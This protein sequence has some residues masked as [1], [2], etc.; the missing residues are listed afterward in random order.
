M[1]ETAQKL[2]D[3]ELVFREEKLHNSL[4]VLLVCVSETTEGEVK[5]TVCVIC[6]RCFRE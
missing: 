3:V 5:G 1:T 6:I 2:G 4:M